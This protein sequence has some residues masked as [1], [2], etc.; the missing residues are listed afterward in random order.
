MWSS[1][2]F[3]DTLN[4]TRVSVFG[5]VSK[6]HLPSDNPSMALYAQGF[7]LTLVCFVHH[8]VF[9]SSSSSYSV[10]VR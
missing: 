6:H 10:G 3:M 7:F 1:P 9:R 2:D 8:A 5:G 4:C